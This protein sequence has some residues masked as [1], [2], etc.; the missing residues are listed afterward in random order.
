MSP[1]RLKASV[2]GSTAT[3]RSNSIRASSRRSESNRNSP[4]ALCARV[5]RGERVVEMRNCHSAPPLRKRFCEIQVRH[6]KTSPRSQRAPRIVDRF[7]V[8]LLAVAQQREIIERERV[9]G[10]GA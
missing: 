4:Y 1:S 6:H 5:E 9:L 2:V 3:E 10:S 7:D 8:S